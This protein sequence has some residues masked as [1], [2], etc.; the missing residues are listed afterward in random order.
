MSARKAPPTHLLAIGRRSLCG[1]DLVGSHSR[2]TRIRGDVTCRPCLRAMGPTKAAKRR[3]ADA[4]LTARVRTQMAEDVAKRR[5]RLDADRKA[6]PLTEL[7]AAVVTLAEPLGEP[8]SAELEALATSFYEPM[9]N[10]RPP[11]PDI[12]KAEAQRVARVAWRLG[13][14]PKP[15]GA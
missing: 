6:E 14:R 12:V 13:A 1:R 2:L 10:G 7:R 8:T 11:T 3:A 15:E 9:W 4:D 5:A